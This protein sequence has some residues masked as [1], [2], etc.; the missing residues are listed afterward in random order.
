M[1]GK[2]TLW[3]IST[4]IREGERIVGFLK[5]AQLLD[6]AIWSKEN[7]CK[8]QILLIKNR[9]YLQDTTNKQ[10]CNGLSNAQ[11]ETL[12]EYD[13]EMTYE[14]AE[15]IFKAK[16]YQDPPMRGRQSMSPLV[17][18]G[19]V[20]YKKEGDRA[21]VKITDV[22]QKLL[23]GEI[24]FED[25]I[26]EMMFKY[27]YP[28]PSDDGFQTW[29]T[30]PFIN[31]LRLIKVV[32]EMCVKNGEKPKGISERELGIFALSLKNYKDVENT[33]K[34]LLKFR[35]KYESYKTES[36]KSDFVE[37]FISEYLYDFNNPLKNCEEY[38]D[39]MVRY[40]RL[41]KYIYIRGKYDHMY[42]DLEPRRYVEIEAILAN[43]KGC[44]QTFTK[45]EWDEYIGTYGVYELP[46]ET[47][48]ILLEMA[49][50]ITNEIKGLEE[51]IDGDISEYTIPTTQT[52][53]KEFIKKQREKR[54]NLQNLLL[55]KVVHHD[56]GK[57][58][59][60]I[61]SLN[62]ILHHNKAKLAKKFSIE[63]EKWTNV[64]MNIINDAKLIKPNYSVGDDN[65]PIY[66]A[67]NGVADIE[68]YYEDFS[69][70]C[71]VTMLTSRDQW[72]NEGQP[73]MRHL[74]CFEICNKEMPSYCIF[75][76][77]TVH[78]DTLN[79]FYI[80]VKYEYEGAKQRIIPITITQL[81]SILQTVKS[82]IPQGTPFKH[83][84]L[85]E[86][87]DDCIDISNVSDSTQWLSS[88]ENKIGLWRMNHQFS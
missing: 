47:R 55:K 33:A 3:S 16:N 63:L 24:S 9:Q 71:E 19:L 6:G 74:R 35:E 46:F 84:M 70:I 27:Q 76:A 50:N 2:E 67:P 34:R 57:I 20:C 23:E 78:K 77:P 26:C 4:T 75:V 41:T 87:L 40:L 66:T 25:M 18:L 44:A 5:T 14:M 61:A 11:I 49:Q 36:E 45:E 42:I 85:Q 68:C 73:V 83:G 53:L 21:V 86:L 81:V 10:V 54:T 32:N 59:E 52:E 7:Q 82:Y 31:T 62:D 39:N 28:N 17:K 80:S 30:K 60:A 51:K 65:E 29:N 79:T 8:F 56:I 64:A 12:S 58:D 69:A 43:D 15:S 1:K 38:A 13:S 37:F 88:I 48:E 72:Y 22:G